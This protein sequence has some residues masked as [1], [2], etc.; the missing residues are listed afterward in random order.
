MKSAL[1]AVM[2]LFTAAAVQAHDH[3]AAGV[4]S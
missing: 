3:R 4:A 2:V 1:A